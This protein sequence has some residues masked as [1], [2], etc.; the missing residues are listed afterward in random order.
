MPVKHFEGGREEGDTEKGGV[1]VKKKNTWLYV[2]RATRRINFL[3]GE[4]AAGP[5][6]KLSIYGYK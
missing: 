6:S 1:L 4:D 5:R 2:A 3:D